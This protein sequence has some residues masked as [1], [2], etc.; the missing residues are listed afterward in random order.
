MVLHCSSKLGLLAYIY[1]HRSEIALS[2]G[3]IQELPISSCSSDFDFGSGK[4]LEVNEENQSLP[5]CFTQAN[6]IILFFSFSTLPIPQN[7]F[8]SLQP[9]Y[10][11]TEILFFSFAPSSIFHPP[12]LG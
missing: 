12:A 4:R 6:E 1:S 9:T 5:L 10:G 7:N 11:A 2:I 3:L 8:L